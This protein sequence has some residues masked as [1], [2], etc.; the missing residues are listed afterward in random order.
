MGV[1]AQVA[2]RATV[3]YAG[4]AVEQGTVE[5]VFATPH[6]PYTRGLLRS[7]PSNPEY[8]GASRLTAIP[9][10]VPDPRT[11]GDE[12]PFANRCPHPHNRCRN[13]FPLETAASSEH[14]FWCWHPDE[15]TAATAS[16]VDQ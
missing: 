5:E 11:L 10:T 2:D 12:C 15:F 9:G 7:L 13:E 8:R 16:E 4:R 3:M 1:V 6:H 14:R